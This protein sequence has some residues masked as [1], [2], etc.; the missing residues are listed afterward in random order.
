MTSPDYATELIDS[1]TLVNQRCSEII[2]TLPAIAS[3]F[4][5]RVSSVTDSFRLSLGNADD[6]FEVHTD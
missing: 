3:F 2:S 5:N 1:E 6:T 4:A